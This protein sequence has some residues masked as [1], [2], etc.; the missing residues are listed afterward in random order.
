MNDLQYFSFFTYYSG[1]LRTIGQDPCEN[2]DAQSAAEGFLGCQY[3]DTDREITTMIHRENL[4]YFISWIPPEDDVWNEGETDASRIAECSMIDL[5]VIGNI[6]PDWFLDKR[7]DETDVQ[8]YVYYTSGNNETVPKHVKQWRKKDFAK[9][10]FTMSMMENP[11]KQNASVEESTHWPLILNIPGEGFG[12][13][14]LQVYRNH[15][16]LSEND[17]ALFKVIEEYQSL[18]GIC[19]DVGADAGASS[20]AGPPVL[21]EEDMIP[22]N[23]NF[24]P[25]SWFSN[26]YTFSPVWAEQTLATSDQSSTAA[27]SS[28]SEAAS[29]L[30]GMSV[31]EVSDHLTVEFCIDGNSLEMEIHF[32]NI[33]PAVDGL[34]PWMAIGYLNTELCAMTPVDGGT[35]PLILLTQTGKV[36]SIPEAYK[37]EL[38]PQAKSADEVILSTMMET[39]TPLADKEGYSD[40]LVATASSAA[41]PDVEVS[42]SSLA[43]Q[44]GTVSLHFKEVLVDSTVDKLY[45]TFAIGTTSE[46]G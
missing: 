4:M 42:R 9:M 19:V 14:F 37:T 18:G 8:Y 39:M 44:E 12:D 34:L 27:S 30:S 22:S 43:D 32:Y 15:K 26:E 7:G 23:L 20:A 16:L 41:V 38:F 45:Y 11:T 5:V 33:M 3:N 21:E 40:V 2:I 31:I 1:L 13:D 10:Y 35:T 29:T 6:R 25:M 24:D 17:I 36:G 46:L 28:S